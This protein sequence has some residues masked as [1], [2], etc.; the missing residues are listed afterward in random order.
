[1]GGR[2]PVL[3]ATEWDI[4]VVAY[5]GR[6]TDM[7]ASPEVTGMSGQIGVS[8]IR[9]NVKT[10]QQRDTGYQIGVAGK[11]EI[12]FPRTGVYRQQCLTAT[13]FQWII[14]G[15]FYPGLIQLGAA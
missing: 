1:M 3:V 4:N 10:Q 5:K 9:G 2:K 11:I 13:G 15:V 12:D 8:K 7:P 6:Q 14:E